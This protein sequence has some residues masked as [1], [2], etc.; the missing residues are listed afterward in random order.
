MGPPVSLSHPWSPP[1][2]PEVLKT[3]GPEPWTRRR[4][5][6]WGRPRPATSPVTLGEWAADSVAP[7]RLPAL[8]RCPGCTSPAAKSTRTLCITRELCLLFVIKRRNHRMSI[9]LNIGGN[10][11]F[12]F[13]FCELFWPNSL[14][15][16][17]NG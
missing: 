15:Y 8:G 7:C 11:V 16:K 17:R 4:E 9:C 3:A 5:D 10:K 12:F 13:S 2:C 14:F 1:A 6:A